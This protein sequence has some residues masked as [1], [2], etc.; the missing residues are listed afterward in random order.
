[1]PYPTD[2]TEPRLGVEAFARNDAASQMAQAAYLLL[3]GYE[4]RRGRE[5]LLPSKSGAIETPPDA[6]AALFRMPQIVVEGRR[7]RFSEVAARESLHAR[8]RREA[9]RYELSRDL[10]FRLQTE[11]RE[12]L[13]AALLLVCVAR[14]DPIVRAAAAAAGMEITAEPMRLIGVLARGTRDGDP[15]VRDLSA[16]SL[17]R[18]Y[19]E[20]S[21]LRRLAARSRR[22]ASA[23]TARTSLLVHGTF[24]KDQEWWQPGGD[25]HSY[26]L[27]NVLPDLYAAADRFEWSGGYSDAARM[28]R[29]QDLQAWASNHSAANPLIIGHSHGANVIFV[30][31]QMGVFMREAVL[32]SC[33]VHW[34]QYAPDFSKVGKLV[35]V[36]V[37]LDLVILADFGG[38]R[39]DDPRI[40]ENVLGVWFNHSATHE[41]AIWQQYAVPTML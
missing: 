6:D 1:M 5:R 18:V 23:G 16:T 33:P 24:A 36:R 21:A 2:V 8:Y 7:Y 31:S 26:A 38:Q 28:L 10:A 19:P 37:R 40:A 15:L 9:D 25:F 41:P 34:P 11:P 17:A 29:A 30:A 20:H 12:S 22:K 32:L 39:F 4:L 35:S 27:A 3:L 14:G 13:A